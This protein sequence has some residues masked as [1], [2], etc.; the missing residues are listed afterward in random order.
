MPLFSSWVEVARRMRREIIV[1]R[2]A[3]AEPRGKR[4]DSPRTL[5]RSLPTGFFVDESFP[6]PLPTGP[7]AEEPLPHLPPTRL[8][9]ADAR[10]HGVRTSP[11]LRESRPNLMQTRLGA[12]TTLLTRDFAARWSSSNRAVDRDAAARTFLS[13]QPRPEARKPV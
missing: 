1:A 3:V 5:L 7:P 4:V 10:S 9:A 12:V 8:R 6:R 13:A 11:R 2:V